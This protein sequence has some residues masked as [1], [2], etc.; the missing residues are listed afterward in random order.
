M[1]STVSWKYYD[2]G[3]QVTVSFTVS[4]HGY[5]FAMSENLSPHEGSVNFSELSPLYNMIE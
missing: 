5:R 1:S 3:C 4:G 2:S